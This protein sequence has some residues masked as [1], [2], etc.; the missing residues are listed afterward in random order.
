[1]FDL[2]TNNLQPRI[3]HCTQPSLSR[4]DEICRARA[5]FSLSLATLLCWVSL[6]IC[7]WEAPI[8][9]LPGEV[10]IVVC[11]FSMTDLGVGRGVF[12]LAFLRHLLAGF[13]SWLFRTNELFT[14]FCSVADLR[15]FKPLVAT[16]LFGLT[17][18]A[19]SSCFGL[20]A[21][22]SKLPWFETS[23]IG[24]VFLISEGLSS[25]DVRH[26][27]PRPPPREE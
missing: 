22:L 1:M 7:D 10:E 13:W 5:D 21:T 20:V 12:W 15:R 16:S 19:L 23:F 17:I 6:V 14:S 24:K 26:D 8:T 4:G 11:P 27:L 2:C 3:W 25:G 18:T 9:G